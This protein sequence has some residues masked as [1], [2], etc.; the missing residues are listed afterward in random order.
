V[1]GLL[2]ALDIREP[3]ATPAAAAPENEQQLRQR[4]R[5][6]KG[7]PIKIDRVNGKPAFFDG[8]YWWI[9]EEQVWKFWDGKKWAIDTKSLMK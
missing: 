3:A 2:K 9:F 7:E 8:H 4:F 5:D 1:K 6:A